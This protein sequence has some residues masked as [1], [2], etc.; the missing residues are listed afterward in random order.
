MK[1]PKLKISDF[2]EVITGGTPSTLVKEY[3]A[4]GTIPWLNSGE[5]NKTYIYESE[6]FIT[7]SGLKSSST[8]LMPPETVLIA[9]TGAT[10]G[11]SALTKIEACANQSV[12]GI[13]PSKNHS[14]D[15]LLHYLRTQRKQ[16]IDKAWGNA[17][18]HISQKF[19]KDLV[20]PLPS[21]QEQNQI[22]NILSKAEILI[23]QRKQSIALLDE[24]LKSTFIEKFIDNNFPLARL[25]DITIKITDGEHRKPDYKEYGVPFISVVNISKGFLSFN[26][27]KFVS[28][29]DHNKFNKRCNPEFE[30]II[31][32]KVGATYGRAVVVDTKNPFSLYVSVA[33][34]KPDKSKVNPYFLNASINHPFVK[35]QADKSIKGAG[36]PDLHLIEIKAFK[37]PFPK[38]EQQIEFAHLVAKTDALKAQ[39]QHSLEELENLYGS[40]SQR[41]FKGELKAEIK[42]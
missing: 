26:D 40:L 11:L 21:L 33:L 4:G 27:C 42:N 8:R 31:Y 7:E 15:Y 14:S 20:I 24:F 2:A 30:D 19:V 10:T 17:Q 35:R 16:I 29:E 37:I 6:N 41:A 18:P 1:W 22:A 23:K 36:V 32:T 12:T 25:E 39:Y 3:W 5:L 9:L 34:I 38:M 28:E 13:L